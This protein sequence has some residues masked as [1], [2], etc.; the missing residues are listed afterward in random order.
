MFK[1]ELDTAKERMNAW[2]DGERLDPPAIGYYYPRP[3]VHLRGV[4][5]HWYLA[6]HND[7]IDAAIH[8]FE[9]KA[10]SIYFGGENIPCFFPNYGPGIM[11]GVLGANVSFYSSTV[12]FSRPT[13]LDEIVPLLE[14]ARLDDSNPWFKRLV[15]VTTEATRRAAG[16]YQVAVTDLGGVLD[17]LAS[18]LDARDI[19]YAM[20]RAPSIIDECRAI[21][22]GKLLA[23]YDK[24]Q[25]IIETGGKGCSSWLNVWCRQRWYPM[26]SDFAYMLSPA[27]FKRFVL[28]DLVAQARAMDRAV[29]HLDGI[30]QLPFLDDLL[31]VDE[32]TAIQWVPG[33]GKAPPGS[34]EWM[35]VYRK[36]Q[37]AG[38][39]IITDA[40]P[41][42]LLH[43]YATLDPRRLYVY[44][45]YAGKIIAD[46]YLPT[47]AGGLGGVDEDD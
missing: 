29:Y 8:D 31:A 17:I 33:A 21:I 19:F 45:V 42:L 15:H 22:L 1:E 39:G 26:Q 20:K 10:S 18:F 7:G 3:E 35:P 37:A 25:G 41:E 2:W 4:W 14:Q 30:G 11:A 13:R 16:R 40:T 5:D 23:T 9:Q 28:P 6:K 34:D 24:L 12:W 27:L 38:K 43:M 32:L 36:I 44:T 47:F 46:Y